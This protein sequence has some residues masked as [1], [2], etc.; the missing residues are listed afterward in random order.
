[1]DQ[2]RFQSPRIPLARARTQLS[3][4]RFI[5]P[6]FLFARQSGAMTTSERRI[7][8]DFQRVNSSGVNLYENCHQNRLHNSFEAFPSRKQNWT[9]RMTRAKCRKVSFVWLQSAISWQLVGVR[10]TRDEECGEKFMT[11]PPRVCH[12]QAEVRVR[13]CF[14][15]SKDSWHLI[16]KRAKRLRLS[17]NLRHKFLSSNHARSRQQSE[18]EKKVS[19]AVKH[20]LLTSANRLG[21]ASTVHT[22]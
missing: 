1:M 17:L 6:T 10:S 14:S 12:R 7:Q 9:R 16:S 13:K 15:R 8:H 21:S 11:S 4:L 5:S 22:Q 18:D 19:K 2:G 20:F 3:D